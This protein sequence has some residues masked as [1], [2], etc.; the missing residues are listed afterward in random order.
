MRRVLVVV[1]HG[2]VGHKV[3][4]V[5]VARGLT[6]E[7]DVVVLGEEEVPAYDRVALSSWF[8]GADLGLAPVD[9]PAVELRRGD[10]VVSRPSV[11][12]AWA[13]SS[14]SSPP[15]TTTPRRRPVA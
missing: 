3:A 5:A 2:M 9:H 4:E 6:D 8:D 11:C 10:P 7:W 13:A 12:S 14:P 15:P 1:G